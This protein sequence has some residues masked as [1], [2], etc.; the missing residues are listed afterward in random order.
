MSA[1]V[2]G[3]FQDH[4]EVLEIEPKANS[5]TIQAAY[6]RLA[7]LYHP[8]EPE[9]GDQEKFDAVNLAYE[10]LCDPE[11][12]KEFDK[13][14][15]LDAEESPKFTGYS[16]FE[17]LGREAELRSAILC[18]LYDRRRIKPFTPSIS[19]RHLEGMLEATSDEL[20]FALWY[21]KQKGL[22]ASDDKSSLQITVGG[23]EFMEKNPPQPDL[24]VGLIRPAA[25]ADQALEY[26]DETADETVDEHAIER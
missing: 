14:K 19:V 2:A 4:Y 22:V 26:S 7:K 6:A 13:L 10:V 1:P 12:R 5:E 20:V 18:V 16:F 15:G 3:R 24:V 23:M 9:T 21:L 11:L 8:Q 25:R 17:S